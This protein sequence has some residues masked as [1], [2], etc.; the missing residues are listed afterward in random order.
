MKVLLVQSYLGRCEPEGAIFPIGLCY[1][2][3]ALKGHNVQIFDP[4]ICR[5]PFDELKNKTISFAPDIVGISLRNIDTTQKK[6]MFYYFKTLKPTVRLVKEINPAI[7]IIV[8]GAGFSMYAREIMDRVP[9]IDYG[10]YLEG[11]ESTP[12]LLNHLDSPENVGG[13][14]IRKSDRVIFTGERPFP[15]VE[16]LPIPKREFA[17]IN[18]YNHPVY[19]NIGIQTKRGCPLKCAYCSYPFLNG[20]MIRTRS[21][22]KVVDEIEYLVNSFKI[23]RLMFADSVFNIPRTH[24]EDICKEIIKRRLKVE[25]AAWFD[26]RRF[27]ERMLSLAIE[28]GCINLSFSPDAASN[29][30]LKALGKDF[31]EKDILRVIRMLR[32]TKGVRVEFNFF[33]TP[34]EQ[35]F[36]GFLKTLLL[37]LKINFFFVG[38]GAANM[39]WIRIEPDT[40]IYDRAVTENVISKDTEMLPETEDESGLRGL[41]YSCPVT[42]GYADPI[43]EFL[44]SVEKKFKSALKKILRR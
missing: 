29:A 14:F 9:E 40:R 1:I 7:K 30:S 6:D 15:D 33:C 11:D 25:W 32:K 41:F 20:S 17:D 31:E 12:E 38:R 4:N 27:S 37:F 8:G 43:F 10:I 5:G 28:A 35:N 16:G 34:P 44:L 13:I 22:K 3:T 39:G 19:T 36:F 23:K 21:T 42:R 24:A 18:K 26:I 2:A